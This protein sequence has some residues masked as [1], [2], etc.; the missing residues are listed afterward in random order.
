MV[1]GGNI[2]LRLES[3]QPGEIFRGFMMQAVD[4]SAN[5]PLALGTFFTTQN[6]QD[7]KILTCS[8]GFQVC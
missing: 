2:T 3:T 1:P 6:S 8:P 4:P 7:S 5:K